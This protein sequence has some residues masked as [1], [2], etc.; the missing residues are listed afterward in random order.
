MTLS[1]GAL[2]TARLTIGEPDALTFD[3]GVGPHHTEADF[4]GFLRSSDPARAI[5]RSGYALTLSQ[6]L[7]LMQANRIELIGRPDGDDTPATVFAPA[8]GD[9]PGP[10]SVFVFEPMALPDTTVTQSATAQASPGVPSDGSSTPSRSSLTAATSTTPLVPR[11]IS[12]SPSNTPMDA[13]PIEIAGS[14]F[15]RRP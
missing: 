2:Q 13:T 7:P 8:E 10:D 14:R 11:A 5:R 9:V 12:L 15:N 3:V 6:L 1:A 4:D